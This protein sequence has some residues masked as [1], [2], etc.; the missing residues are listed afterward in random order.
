MTTEP[1]KRKRSS[2]STPKPKPKLILDKSLSK[3]R[4]PSFALLKQDNIRKILSNVQTK[5]FSSYADPSETLKQNALKRIKD[6]TRRKVLPGIDSTVNDSAQRFV[7]SSYYTSS[8]DYLSALTELV[9][10]ENFEPFSE[11]SVP[12]QFLVQ[13]YNKSDSSLYLCCP[14]ILLG[15]VSNKAHLWYILANKYAIKHMYKLH[16][17]HG[18]CHEVLNYNSWERQFPKVVMKQTCST[19]LSHFSQNPEPGSKEFLSTFTLF[20]RPAIAVISQMVWLTAVGKD[21][22]A[23]P[24][25][26]VNASTHTKKK[27]KTSSSNSSTAKPRSSRQNGKSLST[28]KNMSDDSDSFRSSDS[29]GD[30]YSEQDTDPEDGEFGLN[31]VSSI[32]KKKQL[33]ESAHAWK[34]QKC[35][36]AKLDEASSSS[37]AASKQR[38]AKRSSVSLSLSHKILPAKKRG[39]LKQEAPVQDLVAD[40][41]SLLENVEDPNSHWSEVTKTYQKLADLQGSTSETTSSIC[42]QLLPMMEQ[43]QSLKDQ[44]LDQSTAPQDSGENDVTLDIAPLTN[45]VN[46]VAPGKPVEDLPNC[47]GVL[48]K[49]RKSISADKHIQLDEWCS[50]VFF[51]ALNGDKTT[52]DFIASL[53][54]LVSSEKASNVCKMAL[55]DVYRYDQTTADPEHR[56]LYNVFLAFG[57]KLLYKYTQELLSLKFSPLAPATTSAASLPDKVPDLFSTLESSSSKLHSTVQKQVSEQ[58]SLHDTVS[59]LLTSIVRSK[60]EHDHATE[61]LRKQQEQHTRDINEAANKCSTIE[62][63]VA[64]LE[65][66][67]QQLLTELKESKQKH[68]HFE[69]ELDSLAKQLKNERAANG[70]SQAQIESLQKKYKT[71]EKL[72]QDAEELKSPENSSPPSSPSMLDAED[73]ISLHSARHSQSLSTEDVNDALNSSPVSSPSSE[74]DVLSAEHY[75]DIDRKALKAS[76]SKDSSQND[77]LKTPPFSIN[78]PAETDSDEDHVNDDDNTDDEDEFAL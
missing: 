78:K 46:P 18:N 40:I 59:L 69:T 29:S 34:N 22:P 27:K 53:D 52:I 15:V 33:I 47:P 32:N 13:I 31:S 5:A 4:F 14:G 68:R 64:A 37:P 57:I 41:K 56:R 71:L 73:S 49:I 50:L 20:E 66:E 44:L 42:S 9:S 38:G 70:K 2:S 72:F 10:A 45:A 76:H 77:E 65:K 43:I 67:K 35:P 23:I 54:K 61:S 24:K 26:V 62:D 30:D 17:V 51:Q 21:F 19:L 28:A 12:L 8:K 60:K 75:Q 3:L 25:D 16:H 1:T 36:S 11:D 58:R 7:T 55:F 6:A 63:K 48:S 74:L 39:V